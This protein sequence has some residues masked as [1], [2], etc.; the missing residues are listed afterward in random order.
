MDAGASG[1]LTK[2]CDPAALV[3]ALRTVN[4]GGLY[5]CTDA[6]RALRQMPQ[7]PSKLTILT[8]R[9]KRFSIIGQR[10]KCKSPCRTVVAQP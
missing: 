2:R 6:L 4:G 3:Q 8:P 10:D 5:L 1:Y 9:E 7:Q